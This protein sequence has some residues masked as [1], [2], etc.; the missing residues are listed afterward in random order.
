[1]YHWVFPRVS[2]S[3]EEHA[4][5]CYLHGPPTAIKGSKA[6]HDCYS[7]PL[8]LTALLKRFQFEMYFAYSFVLTILS[9][10]TAVIALFPPS[11]SRG[12]AV[13][14]AKRGDYHIDASEIP[15]MNMKTIRWVLSYFLIS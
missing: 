11:V 13:P 2:C 14:I 7:L 9:F 1:M 4:V 15:G 8:F 5:A 6:P 10:L 3:S 12:I